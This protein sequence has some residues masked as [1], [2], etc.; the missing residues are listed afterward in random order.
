MPS[1]SEFTQQLDMHVRGVCGHRYKPCRVL[2]KGTS[3]HDGP[4]IAENNVAAHMSHTGSRSEQNREL[5]FLRN[6]VGFYYVV[7]GFLRTRRFQHG[8]VREARVVSVVLFIL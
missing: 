5:Q 7:L 8:H 4:P 6:A 3:P 2:L 1:L